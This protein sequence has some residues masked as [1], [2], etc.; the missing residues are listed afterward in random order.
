MNENCF[1]FLLVFIRASTIFPASLKQLFLPFFIGKPGLNYPQRSAQPVCCSLFV[2]G[3]FLDT[4]YPLC[5]STTAIASTLMD[6]WP[7]KHLLW[8]RLKANTLPN[9]STFS[10]ACANAAD[11]SPSPPLPISC[12]FSWSPARPFPSQLVFF[13]P[14][15]ATYLLSLP[16][17][18]GKQLQKEDLK[19]CFHKCFL[20]KNIIAGR[21]K[22]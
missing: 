17:Y 21:L 22:L 19:L 9:C 15:P 16:S 11:R 8:A 14:F 2:L 12:S 3:N 20:M 7:R 5:L 1:Y 10:P 6:L 13:F 4:C 18:S